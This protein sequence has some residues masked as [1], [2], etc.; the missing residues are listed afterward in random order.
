MS[1]VI[2]VKGARENNLKNLDVTIPKNKLVVVT[3]ISGS[4]KSS[5][6][7]DTLY[8]E[9]QRRYM[10]SLSSYA[11]QFLHLED[12]PDVDYIEGLSPAIAVDQKTVLR[13]PRSTVGTVTE[14]YDYMRLLYARIGIPYSPTTGKPIVK[15]TISSIVEEVKQLP[16]GTKIYLLAPIVRGSKGE[17]RAEIN[18]MRKQGYQRI[19]I[20]G[21]MYLI[22]EIPE[23]DK[24]IKHHID[25]VVDRIVMNDDLG[26][27]IAD[28]I[29]SCMNLTSGI[30][31]VE[32]VECPHDMV[33]EDCSPEIC[34]LEVGAIKLFSEKYACPDSGF[35]IVD[36]EP[37]IFS[38]NSPYGACDKC[39]G[40]GIE[41]YID[42]TLIVKNNLSIR[43][44]AILPLG[45]VIHKR[46]FQVF[47]SLAKHYQFSLDIPFS[48][49]PDTVKDIIILGTT[50]SVDVNIN[51][52]L[53][54]HTK[55]LSYEGIMTQLQVAYGRDDLSV[56]QI[57]QYLSK[58]P[59]TSCKG[60][61]L[62]KTSLCI[63]INNMHVG[64][65]CA[66]TVKDLLVWIQGLPE[67][68]SP[69]HYE[70]AARILKE[71]TSRIMFLCNVGLEYLTLSRSSHTLSGGESQRIRLASQVGLGLSGVLYVLDEPSIGLH[72]SDN[73]KLI[74]T[75]KNL[76]DL[77]NTVVVVEH[78]EDTI[79]AADHIIDI[80]PGAGKHGG[81][82][83]AQGSVENVI[84]ATNSIT[85]NYLSGRE[86]IEVPSQRRLGK[87]NITLYGA[88]AHNLKNIDFSLNTGTL[89]CVTG[90]SGSGKSTLTMQLFYD[91]LVSNM[92]R[93]EK[94]DTCGLY[95]KLEGAE[96]IDRVVNIT[97]SPIGRTPRS[98]P[99]T[100]TG[101]FTLIRE[102]FIDV[103][104]SRMRG[105]KSGRFSFNVK[106]GRCEIC[107]GDGVLKIE[108]H[109]LPDVY[110]KC[111]ECQ[112]KRYNNETLEI[113]YKGKS[114][115]EILDMTID[116]AHEF[117]A[118]IPNISD[119]ITALRDVGLGYLNLG[120]PAT[121]LS[122]GES[123]RV[124][125]AKEL[126]KQ[127]TGRTLYILDEPTT[128][129]HQH[130]ISMLLKVL[131]RLVDL[132]NTVLVIEHNMDV[133]KTADYIVDI[134]PGGGSNGGHIMANCT[135]EELIKCPES[136]TGKFLADYF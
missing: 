75:L 29:E 130:D 103:P 125:L 74:D 106:G 7:F 135:P 54:K 132:G 100:Y 12:K 28:G 66:M 45:D 35:E 113:K 27:R 64:Q 11:R 16:S 129:L 20:D 21:I 24:N 9:G 18:K 67:L 94:V 80:G 36:V 101:A 47:E 10:D 78:D 13:S 118:N 81:R 1:D 63:K 119:K 14:I 69:H 62:K 95:D 33:V 34:K 110:I 57:K 116:Q 39:E 51:D 70:I 6:A 31:G 2:I 76:R 38:F 30:V 92:E 50:Q 23:L 84:N 127:S 128:G 126:C 99:A 68:L 134:G 85:G 32:I 3:G 41:K 53:V 4:G 37:R 83:L 55:S 107:K 65:V 105:Y 61:R 133:I 124:K 46:Y 87:R 96:Y 123:Q 117:F 58:R 59:C 22:D 111:D 49:L 48:D 5:F 44:G 86:C 82:L 56:D 112:G 109:F 25:V 17:Y 77:G 89:T 97:Q 131:K 115:S 122:G 114:I 90:V 26:N 73:I 71:M 136:I 72:Q 52:G 91:A 88:R 121:K 120:H 60:Y 43:Q 19:K 42:R 40:L 102:K 98:N 93:K 79:K 108:M 8:A 15:Q 104:E